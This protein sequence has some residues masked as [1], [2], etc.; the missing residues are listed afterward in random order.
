[1]PTPMRRVWASRERPYKA[2]QDRGNNIASQS[3]G[4]YLGELSRVS[5]RGTTAAS[6]LAGVGTNM[7][8]QVSSNNNAA[9]DARGNAAL[10]NA[11][12]INGTINNLINAGAYAYGSSYGKKT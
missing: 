8:G 12:N 10:V 4:G 2:L 1:M 9:A 3:F 5:D 11:S 7:V 6:S